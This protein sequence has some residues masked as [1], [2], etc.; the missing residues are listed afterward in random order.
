MAGRLVIRGL[1]GWQLKEYE[2][3]FWGNENAQTLVMVVQIYEYT[4]K[5]WIVYFK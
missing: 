1:E 5:H 3:T 4:K 2:V